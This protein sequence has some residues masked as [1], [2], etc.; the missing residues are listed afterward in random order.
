MKKMTSQQN[1][2]QIRY[3]F[4]ENGLIREQIIKKRCFY[5]I[6]V[7]NFTILNKENSVFFFILANQKPK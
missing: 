4:L 1:K 2:F 6:I 5:Q 3:F 7:N